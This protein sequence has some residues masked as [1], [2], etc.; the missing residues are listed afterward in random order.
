MIKLFKIALILVLSYGLMLPQFAAADNVASLR[1]YTALDE[2]SKA[3]VLKNWQR[4]REQAVTCIA[5]TWGLPINRHVTM[6]LAGID[7]EFAGRLV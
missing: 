3:P 1:G 4:D 2:D 6:K 7:G 5:E